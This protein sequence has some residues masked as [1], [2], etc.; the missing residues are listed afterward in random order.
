MAEIDGISLNDFKKWMADQKDN[1][2][3]PKKISASDLIGCLTEAKISLKKLTTK[4]EVD[5]GNLEE[6]AKDF[7]KNGGI[8]INID[9][10]QLLVEVRS[11]TF[12]IPRFFVRILSKPIVEP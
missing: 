5:Q 6:M 4:I 10:N 9:S 12:R 11:G 8:I 2:L 3:K 7:K 1:L